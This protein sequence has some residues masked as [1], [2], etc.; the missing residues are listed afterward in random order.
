[1]EEVK[2][3]MKEQKNTKNKSLGVWKKK[4]K[5]QIVGIVFFSV[6]VF[7]GI[8]SFLLYFRIDMTENNIYSI[9]KTSIDVLKEVDDLVYLDY[10]ISPK[11]K[12]QV[13]QTRQITDI[14]QEMSVRSSGNI[15][16]KEIDT[17]GLSEQELQ[18]VGLEA[19]QMQFIEKNEASFAV[20]YSGIVISYQNRK[21]IIPFTLQ[22]SIIEYQVVSKILEIYRDDQRI[23]GLLTLDPAYDSENQSVVSQVLSNDFVV[24]DLDRN[25]F[26]F[27][28]DIDVIFLL[29]SQN[30]SDELL[31]YIDQFVLQGKGVFFAPDRAR[32]SLTPGLSVTKSDSRMYDLLDHYG[33]DIGQTVVLDVL[34][35]QIPVNGG[36]GIQIFQSY[37]MWV[38]IN[39]NNVDADHPITNKFAGLD[40]YWTNP[41]SNKE[42]VND[43]VS[44]IV[45]TSPDAWTVGASL[46]EGEAF[47]SNPD[48]TGF[49]SYRTD[50]NKQQYNLISVYNGPLTSA[51]EA[52]IIA[53]PDDAESYI[54]S[55]EQARFLVAGSS[56]FM[57][58][59]L[60]EYTRANYNFSFVSN[61]SDWLSS[62]LELLKIKSKAV[63]NTQLNKITDES[64]K[65]TY[66][67]IVQF[68]NT[69]LIPFII[70]IVGAVVLFMRRNISRRRY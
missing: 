29:G 18:E 49:R 8:N 60:Y 58:G 48:P 52:D 42:E 35:K 21:S 66:T 63:R 1:M 24:R 61:T 3:E 14:L 27:P 40:M 67:F 10:Y 28:D 64:E 65:E 26:P 32:V 41:I 43:Y 19:R 33:F 54:S 46:G 2:K 4:A 53:K 55:T 6:L 23:I 37:P 70:I 69:F 17:E 20:V 45:K 62:D 12:L 5:E 38:T 50:E 51:V 57:A 7:V 22:S 13:D 15:I 39:S 34:N 16:V 36:P 31:Y 68:I 11:L 44:N 56:Q 59:P 25:V 30:V 47:P 9:S